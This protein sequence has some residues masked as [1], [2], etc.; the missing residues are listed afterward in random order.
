MIMESLSLC[1]EASTI[2][3]TGKAIYRENFLLKSWQGNVLPTYSDIF[4]KEKHNVDLV[5]V[6][7]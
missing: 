7:H 3:K 5:Q 4:M 1:L 6:K 2:L